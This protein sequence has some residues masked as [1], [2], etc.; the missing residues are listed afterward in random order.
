MKRL[1]LQALGLVPLLLAGCGAPQYPLRAV[2]QEWADYLQQDHALVPGDVLTITVLDVPDLAQEVTISPTG[3]ANLRRIAEP[4]RAVGLTMARF[5]KTVEELYARVQAGAE[6]SVALKTPSVQ[7]VFVMGEVSRPGVIPWTSNMT[8]ARAVAAAGGFE[9]TAKTSDVLVV[10]SERSGAPRTI[11][12]NLNDILDGDSVDFLL[13]PG[14]VVYAQTS[15][16]ADAGNFVE[17][18][19]RRLLPFSITGVS[20]GTR[21]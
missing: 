14:D 10:R 4:V 12:V 1:L 6:V 9:I 21:N 19:I 8:L 16:V 11:R 17:L 15:A 2:V 20:L 3:T 7:T 13:L 18:Y 5:R